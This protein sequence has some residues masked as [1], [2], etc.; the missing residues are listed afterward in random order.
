MK[1][2]KYQNPSSPL[3]PAKVYLDGKWVELE[4]HG[5]GEL[6]AGGR[7]FK[8]NSKPK[9][10]TGNKEIVVT[11]KGNT[12]INKEN[13]KPEPVGYSS[14]FHSED[15]I[16]FINT[17]T[18]GG[19]NNLSPT[20]WVRRAYDAKELLSGN[21]N[22]SDY[23][24]SW[25]NGNNG[26]VSNQF[27]E[28][29][30][31]WSTGINLIGD[32]VGFG[33]IAS[34]LSKTPGVYYHGSPVSGLKQLKSSYGGIYLASTKDSAKRY[35]GLFDGT[36]SIYKIEN[37]NLGDKPLEVN[38]YFLPNGLIPTKQLPEDVLANLKLKLDGTDN[39]AQAAQD[40][41]YSS[42]TF[43][44]VLDSGK[45]IGLRS[46]LPS[47]MDQTV[48]FN[49]LTPTSETKRFFTELGENT[50]KTKVKNVANNTFKQQTILPVL[51]LERMNLLYS[52]KQG[53]KIA[54]NNVK[55][56]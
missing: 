14:A 17:L 45:Q 4:S 26:I 50:L 19:L 28:K 21:M 18:L 52:K 54:I 40:A 27:A 55:Y 37:V 49:N 23:T 12:I 47:W 46:F 15:T 44:N 29:H 22:W 2:K 39:I 35:G 13:L 8:V 31:Y 56:K 53:G 30:P 51:G 32:G 20:Q 16:P 25:I 10:A 34:N 1:I 7:Q 43:K 36:G 9:S 24:N 5:G 41:G 6:S 38:G 3:K 33:K 48:V 42:V 11:P